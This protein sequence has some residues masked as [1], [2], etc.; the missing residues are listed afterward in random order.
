MES[1]TPLPTD[2]IYKFLA[3]FSLLLVIFSVGAVIYASN[4]TNAVGFEH[5]V[6]LE[7]L[8]AVE[9][10]TLEQTICRKVIEKKLRLLLLTRKPMS[11]L[12]RF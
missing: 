2:S 12:P 4:S 1:K 7:V 6:E 8:Q 3:M 9:E 11:A 10:P 5:W